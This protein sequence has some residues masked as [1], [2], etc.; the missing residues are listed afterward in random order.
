MAPAAHVNAHV[1]T[2][3]GTQLFS[4]KIRP[5]AL[6]LPIRHKAL[7]RMLRGLATYDDLMSQA[8][9]GQRALVTV[10]DGDLPTKRQWA[11]ITHM[12][13]T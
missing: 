4:T 13:M 7:Q 1:L 12:V 8:R 5:T 6:M 10:A 3:L 11:H 9:T 2:T